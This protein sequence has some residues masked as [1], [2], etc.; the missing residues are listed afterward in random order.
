M[1]LRVGPGSWAAVISLK[2]TVSGAVAQNE[3]SARIA[4]ARFGDE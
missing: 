1:G 4:T 2:P 3:R